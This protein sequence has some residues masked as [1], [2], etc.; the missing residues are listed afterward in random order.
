[1]AKITRLIS[2]FFMVFIIFS[3]CISSADNAAL[4]NITIGDINIIQPPSGSCQYKWETWVRNN[5]AAP[6]TQ[7]IAVQG[8]Q[9]GSETWAGATGAG[10]TGLAAG[11]NR[12]VT[13][14]WVRKPGMTT[15]R[16]ELRFMGS[17]FASKD[18]ALPQE[19]PVNVKIGDV[20]IQ[21]NGYTVNVE[22]KGAY[23]VTGLIVQCY[24]AS[25]SSPNN[26]TPG[27][28]GTLECIPGGG[29]GQRK[30]VLSQGWNSGYT[31]FK[32][33]LFGN[34][35]SYDEKI[36][37]TG[38]DVSQPSDSSGSTEKPAVIIPQNKIRDK[39]LI[40]RPLRP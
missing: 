30:A 4:D 32:Y 34:G 14:L 26:W 15:F 2:L 20:V 1:M 10:V 27:G 11:E 5:N 7:L 35:S 40:K 19:P 29:T 8:L 9:G 21:D 6:F 31:L 33:K 3:P 36:I 39:R 18:K 13:G 37:N 16:I 25:G 38:S 22:N 24:K 23:P 28:G 17:T 12:K